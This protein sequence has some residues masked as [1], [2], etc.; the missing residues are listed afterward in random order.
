MGQ[1]F[2]KC[3]QS[4][5]SHTANLTVINIKPGFLRLPFSHDPIF[6]QIR[7]IRNKS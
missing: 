4:G 1:H 5:P 3:L 7:V 6:N 2:H